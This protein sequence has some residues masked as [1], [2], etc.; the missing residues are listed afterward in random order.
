MVALGDDPRI[1][2]RLFGDGSSIL[3]PRGGGNS[4]RPQSWTYEA[5]RPVAIG[6]E[7]LLVFLNPGG[8]Q[9]L[10]SQTPPWL[11]PGRSSA[12]RR[13]SVDLL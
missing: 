1:R 9:D 3:T 12:S 13:R 8:L 4:R 11:D 7:F 2:A 5:S 6:R 10:H